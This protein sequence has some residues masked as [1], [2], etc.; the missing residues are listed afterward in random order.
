MNTK[1][2]HNQISASISGMDRLLLGGNPTRDLCAMGNDQKVHMVYRYDLRERTTQ[3][4]VDFTDWES[5]CGAKGTESG[6]VSD[7]TCSSVHSF[8]YSVRAM[9]CPDCCG[10]M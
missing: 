8:D 5:S 6:R 2:P 9:W 4:G 3:H 7:G 1:H 10:A